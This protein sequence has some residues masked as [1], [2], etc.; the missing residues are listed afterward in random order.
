MQCLILR[1][2]ESLE[3]PVSYIHV[4]KKLPLFK[5]ISQVSNSLY[6][7]WDSGQ[8]GTLQ[9]S[10]FA[11]RAGGAQLTCKDNLFIV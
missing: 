6:L 10:I 8:K 11:I 7:K 4:V 5:R 3:Y 1:I 2:L 9:I